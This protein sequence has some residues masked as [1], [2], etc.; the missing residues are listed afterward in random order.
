MPDNNNLQASVEDGGN[1]DASVD[2]DIKLLQRKAE[3]GWLDA[4]RWQIVGKVVVY[5]DIAWEQ[6][7]V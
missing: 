1:L 6:L 3:S 7:Q 5:R 2:E 4:D